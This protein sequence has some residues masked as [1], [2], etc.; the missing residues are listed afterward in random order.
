MKKK[1]LSTKLECFQ[2]NDLFIVS[3]L[4]G[5][6]HW[7][8]EFNICLLPMTLHFHLSGISEKF[9]I[10]KKISWEFGDKTKIV[11]IT[12]RKQ[13]PEEAVVKHIFK[14]RNINTDTLFVQASVYTSTHI[15]TTPSFS[16]GPF[17]TKIKQ[18][19]INPEEFKKLII[20]F[21]LQDKTNDVICDKLAINIQEI[22]TRLSYA[23]NF[24]NYTFRDDMV[25]DALV[26]MI[27]ALRE[28]KFRPEVGNPFSYFT[29]IAYHAFC[30]RIKRENKMYDALK[31]YQT[32]IYE[33][34]IDSG[35]LPLA[36]LQ[37]ATNNETTEFENF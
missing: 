24:I 14:Q 26:K 3:K 31:N 4:D 21:Y 10:I 19:Y 35:Y 16:L 8:Q 2:N 5:S 13:V 30:N 1:K 36:N 25:G 12:N 34:F 20:D 15:Y 11:S 23:P 7:T 6:E 17:E 29:K 22:A 33:N 27:K 28:Q 18:N 32:D 9:D 37:N